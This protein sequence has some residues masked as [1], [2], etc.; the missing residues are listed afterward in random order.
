MAPGWPGGH[1]LREIENYLG[2]PNG[3]SGSDLAHRAVT[4]ARRFG[5]EILTTQRAPRQQ[6]LRVVVV[7]EPLEP[8]PYYVNLGTGL[9]PP[10]ITR[11][12]VAQLEVG[13]FTPR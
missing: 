5:G 10:P 1:E 13:L 2:F 8:D 11:C 6:R 12:D 7:V 3:L 4:L 9:I